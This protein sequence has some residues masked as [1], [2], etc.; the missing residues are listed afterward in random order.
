MVNPYDAVPYPDLAYGN[1]HP[2]RL[3]TMARLVGMTP[4][5]V[6]T[7]RVLE[8]G[9]AAGGNLLPMAYALPQAEFVG[10]DYSAYQIDEG[11]ARIRGLGLSNIS[12]ICRNLVEVGDEVGDFD[13]V[14]AHGVY[15]WTPP[16]VR[17]G[18]L[19]LCKRVLRPNG[20]AFISYNTYPGWKI[21]GIIRDAM[22]YHGRKAANPTEKAAAAR[23]MLGALAD[24]ATE[25]AYQGIFRSYAAFL[26]DG[27]KGSSDAFLLHDELEEVNDPVYFYQFVEH[28]AQHGLAYL[29][30]AELHD[31][32]PTV[33][34]PEAQATLQRLA[35]DAIALEQYMD[36]LRNRMFRQTLLCHAEVSATR[37]LR[38]EPV[39]GSWI[40]STATRAPSPEDRPNVAVFKTKAESTLATDHPLTIAAMELLIH[41]APHALPFPDLVAAARRALPPQPPSPVPDELILAANLLRAHGQSAELVEIHSYS[42]RLPDHV[43]ERPIASAVARLQNESRDLVTNLWHQR[44]TLQPRQREILA[45]LDGSHRLDELAGLVAGG[46]APDEI[47]ATVRWFGRTA[48]LVG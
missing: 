44:V 25:P 5:P 43:S 18:L 7:C 45:L 9:C 14:I 21:T 22:L 4:A 31:V 48:L 1:T 32:L 12:L 38:P 42:P 30:E 28:A 27:I 29:I 2:D 20:V 41:R 37:M 3:A 10:I 40:R 24:H 33:F 6:A 46:A 26:G 16:A 8:V 36:F 35:D 23:E 47:E 13:Y 17:D 19:A 39:M 34:K 11:Q 15:S